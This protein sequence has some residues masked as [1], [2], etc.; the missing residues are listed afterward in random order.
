M[1]T[2]RYSLVVAGLLT[3]LTDACTD[4]RDFPQ[5]Y[6][7]CRLVSEMIKRSANGLPANET[8]AF[9]GRSFGVAPNNTL[10]YR[11]DE[12][13]RLTDFGDAYAQNAADNNVTFTYEYGP[14]RLTETKRGPGSAGGV[15]PFTLNAQGLI[16]QNQNRPDQTYSYDDLGYLTGATNEPLTNENSVSTHTIENGNLVRST[17]TTPT[18]ASVI[19]YEYDLTRPNL[20]NPFGFRGTASRNLPLK[21]TGTFT[22]TPGGSSSFSTRVV[23]TYRYVFDQQGRVSRRLR[24]SVLTDPDG[25]VA[26]ENMLVSDFSYLCR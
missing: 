13:G 25:N 9:E 24:Y 12:Q 22:F 1:P 17:R 26:S 6:A 18:Q 20:P 15:T 23:T 4:H 3:L 16:T 7:T 14:G 10:T 5:P 8:I 21:E 11:Y 2:Y 19:V